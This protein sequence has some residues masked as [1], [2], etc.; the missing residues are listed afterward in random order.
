MPI[1]E[2]L[3]YIK[4]CPFS[5]RNPKCSQFAVGNGETQMKISSTCPFS[6]SNIVQSNGNATINIE[7]T[8]LIIVVWSFVLVIYEFVI[9]NE[10]STDKK[11]L[12]AVLDHIS[13]DECK[14]LSI[15]YCKTLS[16]CRFK[17]NFMTRKIV[18]IN[19][20]LEVLLHPNVWCG[21]IY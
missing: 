14:T 6:I 11:Q 10:S 20:I 7:Q 8:W 1:N 13:Q 16:R 2:C 9:S 5:S 12:V 3:P 21:G 4:W 19:D 15:T 17:V 18:R